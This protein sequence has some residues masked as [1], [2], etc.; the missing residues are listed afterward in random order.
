M[1]GLVVSSHRRP[2]GANPTSLSI[3]LVSKDGNDLSQWD[4]SGKQVDNF[5]NRL[6]RTY[7]NRPVGELPHLV[8]DQSSASLS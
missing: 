2:H 7:S 8:D 1:R 5:A 3:S 4:R 6:A